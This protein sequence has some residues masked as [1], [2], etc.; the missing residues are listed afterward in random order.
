M[1]DTN[2]GGSSVPAVD[3][4]VVI[5]TSASMRDEAVALSEAVSGAI[6]AAKDHCPSDLRVE[7]L[8]V[9]GTFGKTKFTTS[10][11]KYL[12]GK[13]KVDPA[14]LKGRLKGTVAEGG[15]QEDGA[16]A[17]ED[18]TNHFDWRQGAKKAILYLTD[19]ALYGGGL[20]DQDDVK[21]ATDAI[22]TAKAGEVRVHTYLG[23]SS[24]KAAE[25]KKLASE[26]ARV[27]SE[28]GGQAFTDKDALGGFQALLEKV[29]CG[30]RTT[31]GSKDDVPCEDC[32]KPEAP[33]KEDPPAQKEPPRVVNDD[34]YAI[35]LIDR[36]GWHAN[37]A[38]DNCDIYVHDA[39][40]G[41]IKRKIDNGQAMGQSNAITSDGWSYYI[42]NLT[43][44]WREKAGRQQKL[45]SLSLNM[46]YSTDGFAF[47]KDDRGFI[48]HM[49][50][51]QIAHFQHDPN[52]TNIGIQRL[53]VR[54]QG[55]GPALLG[56]NENQ[57]TTDLAF[58]GDDRAYFLGYHGD[59]WVV[60]DTRSLTNWTAR[61]MCRVGSLPLPGHA[62][63]L[64]IAFDAQ[65]TVYLSGGVTE[66]PQPV[67]VGGLFSRQFERW[68]RRFI[69]KFPMGSPGK[70]QLVYDGGARSGS[71]GD[72]ASQAFPK[73]AKV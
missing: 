67:R 2:A 13:A 10:V 49:K 45:A 17:I 68:S 24:A 65:G 32:G 51:P 33:V 63:Y 5:D 40:T 21:A 56:S 60:D 54:H 59:I 14:K 26:L 71:Y 52:T 25:R 58:D 11:R 20:V 61:H 4:V 12:T 42:W 27:S 3:L 1:A 64:G 46:G 62:R 72:L 6:A 53:T 30:S 50:N 18:V 19:E 38:A 43:T 73:F 23:T 37:N 35:V 8:G 48:L 41:Q 29:I 31:P 69:A 44:V 39:R 15:A 28:T 36:V 34:L 22:E 47:R 7:Y 66:T 57:W 16:L 9:E 70:L 55:G